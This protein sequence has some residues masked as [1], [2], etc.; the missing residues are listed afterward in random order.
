LKGIVVY[1]SRWGNLRTIAENVSRGIEETGH[2]LTLMDVREIDFLDRDLDFV[3]VGSPTRFGRMSRPIRRFIK[4]NITDAWDGKPFAAF[5]T[6]LESESGGNASRDIWK[7]LLAKGLEPLNSPF[8]ARVSH[9]KGPLLD[10]E[11]ERAHEFGKVVG[12]GLKTEIE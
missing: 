12:E 1:Y 2:T 4:R 5:G 7:K 10:G 9:V 11:A 6:C 8:C 3:V